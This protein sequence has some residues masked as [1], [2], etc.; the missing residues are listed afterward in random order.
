M[1]YR[2]G[3][4]VNPPSPSD[5]NSSVLGVFIVGIDCHSLFCSASHGLRFIC[6]KAPNCRREPS[7]WR[8][9][10]PH[11]KACG[12]QVHGVAYSGN[13][14]DSPAKTYI[15]AAV[16]KSQRARTPISSS[17]FAEGMNPLFRIRTLRGVSP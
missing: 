14:T 3:L 17:R 2:V 11:A 10:A 15:H 1:W 7:Q 8:A 16:S 6:S 5:M 9:Q 12:R 4:C 13:G